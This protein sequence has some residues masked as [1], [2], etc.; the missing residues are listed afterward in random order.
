MIGAGRACG[1]GGF[2]ARYLAEGHAPDQAGSLIAWLYRRE[3]VYGYRFPGSWYDIG[4]LGQLLEA[5]NRMRRREGLPERTAYSL[6][7]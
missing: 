1:P 3:P 4:N 2:V 6:D 7:P 5:D